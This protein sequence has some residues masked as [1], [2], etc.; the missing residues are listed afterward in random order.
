MEE[1]DLDEM[2]ATYDRP[3]GKSVIRLI[4][5]LEQAEQ[6]CVKLRNRLDAMRRQ[7]DGYR[8]HARV[9]PAVAQPEVNSVEELDQLP[10]GSVVRGGEYDLVGEKIRHSPY[11][12]HWCTIGEEVEAYERDLLPARVLYRPEVES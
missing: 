3:T 5:R 1:L 11:P 12:P 7:R 8:H 2:R 9:A 4:E 6:D 10:V